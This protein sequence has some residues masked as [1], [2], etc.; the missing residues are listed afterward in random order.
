LLVL[1]NLRFFIIICVHVT[2]MCVLTWQLVRC[3][4][5][6]IGRRASSE[7]RLQRSRFIGPEETIARTLQS[8]RYNVQNSFHWNVVALHRTLCIRA[9]VDGDGK[10]ILIENW[11]NRR[12]EKDR[13]DCF[14]ESC[15][16]P[17][18]SWLSSREYWSIQL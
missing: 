11:R 5:L 18:I 9:P 14:H 6:E 16:R 15:R 1:L 7:N 12:G 13:N 4:S 3:V 10:T 2:D 8:H 17:K